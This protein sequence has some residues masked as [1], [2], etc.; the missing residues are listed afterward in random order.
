VTAAFKI[1]ATHSDASDHEPVAPIDCIIANY[2]TEPPQ[3]G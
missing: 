1:T 3:T 2:D